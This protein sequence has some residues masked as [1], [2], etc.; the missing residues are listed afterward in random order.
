MIIYGS[1]FLRMKK[2]SDHSCRKT[3]NPHFIF[4]NFLPKIV[5]FIRYVKI[6]RA[7]LA[8]ADN[9]T[10]RKKIACWIT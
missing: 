5:L 4:N 7:G 9:I 3:Q 1:V 6:F 8:A 2:I 10:W